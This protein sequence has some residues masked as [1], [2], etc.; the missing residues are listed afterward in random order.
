ML[1]NTW[2]V[3]VIVVLAGVAAAC[4]IYPGEDHFLFLSSREQV[5]AD[6]AAWLD[7]GG[8]GN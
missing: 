4:R 7:R 5:L 2:K 3:P 1:K 6:I 8:S